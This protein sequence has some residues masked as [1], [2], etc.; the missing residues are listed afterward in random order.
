MTSSGA[1]PARSGT[2]LSTVFMGTPEIA[3]PALQLLSRLTRVRVVVTQP[4]R[5]AGRGNQLQEPA[6]KRAARALGL[7]VWQPETLRGQA[8]AAALQDADLFVVMAYGE[9]LRQEVLD[10][11][12]AGCINL[13]ASLLPRWRGA[14]PLQ[15]V[16]RAGERATGVTAM[17]MVPALDAGPIYLASRLELGERTTLPE[18]HDAIAVT[19]AD[20]LARLLAAWPAPAPTPQDETQVTRCR[21][22]TA[23]DGRLRFDCSPLELERWVRAYT[24]TPGCW[25]LAGTQRLRVLAVAPRPARADLAPLAPGTLAVHAGELLV[26]CAG[27]ACAILRLQLAGKREME[28]DDF[29]RGHRIPERL[30]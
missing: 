1:V 14:S 13:H 29:L 19:A 16:L 30:G 11:P 17:R 15:A 12:R 22:L 28:A 20:A 25:A 18:L 21:K 5:P 23:E 3:V 10:L 7:P 8:G 9:L 24:P 2:T 27:G 6:V 26:G 4:D